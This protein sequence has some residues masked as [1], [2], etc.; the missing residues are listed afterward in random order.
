MNNDLNEC[1]TRSILVSAVTIYCGLYYLTGHLTE[2]TKFAFFVFIVTANAYFL[3][4][5]AMK[6]FGA[7]LDL[8]VQKIPCLKK[9][10]GY[11]NKVKDGFED[12]M[13]VNKHINDH[14]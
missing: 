14:Y 12:D 6:M 3:V 11:I 1:E 2:T 9:K 13:L 4:Y 8:V 10:F 7:G 5:W